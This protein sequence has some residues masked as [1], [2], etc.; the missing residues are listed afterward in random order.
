MYNLSLIIVSNILASC[1]DPFDISNI[2]NLADESALHFHLVPANALHSQLASQL[3]VKVPSQQVEKLADLLC[4]SGTLLLSTKA[5]ILILFL[6]LFF[7]LYPKSKQPL[8]LTIFVESREFKNQRFLN[9]RHNLVKNTQY[10]S[11]KNRQIKTYTNVFTG[12]K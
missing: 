8:K 7:M 4:K 3:V 1:I 11:L 2:C 5:D 12:I 6:F 10:F 9:I